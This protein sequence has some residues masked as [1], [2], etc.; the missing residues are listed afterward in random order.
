MLTGHV[1]LNVTD[2]DRSID[3]YRRIFDLEL[4]NQP[5]PADPHR[6]ARL[7]H[8]DRLVLTLWPQS[9]GTFAADTPGLHHLAFEAPGPDEIRRAQSVLEQ[10][11]AEFAYEGVV[12]HRDG[13]DSGGLFFHDPDGTRLELSTAHAPLTAAAPSGTA[14]TCG[15]F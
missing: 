9:T 13:A 15:F 7:G 6:Y 2:L 5:D 4:L 1:G 10:I 3:F 8:G 11:G 14:P 12:P